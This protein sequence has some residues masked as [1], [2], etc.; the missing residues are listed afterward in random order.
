[1]HRS[2]II[3]G[4]LILII[5]A[6]TPIEPSQPEEETMVIGNDLT[7]PI[8]E[9]TPDI[10]T[11]ESLIAFYSNQDGN[12][13]IYTIQADG[14]GLQRLTNNDAFDDSPALSPDGKQIVFL[15]ARNDPY[16]IFPDFKY[17]IYLMDS[18]GENLRRLT[19]TEVGEDHPSWSPD[20]RKIL[21]DA[22][23]NGDGYY[24]I[25]TLDVEDLKLTQLTDNKAND[26]FAEW[27]PD[28]LW[29]AFSS[30]RNGNWDIFIMDADGNFQ[31][32]LTDSDNWELFPAWSPSVEQIAYQS[33]V[34]RS[35]NTDVFVM[36]AD[37][38]EAHQLTNSPGF[39]ESPTWSPDGSKIAFQ[40][41]RNGNFEIYVM[42]L[43]GS[44]QQPLL[45]LPSDELWPSWSL[46]ISP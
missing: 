2:M 1:M 16:P 45:T 36:N 42:N 17:E 5:T 18:N 15:S 10:P 46:I 26:Q 4:L 29:I 40:T 8:E 30:D 14:S 28:S 12:L 13:E 41:W 23:Y 39:D 44:D 24:E 37:G 34:P 7:P 32:A 19:Q 20:G 25:Y 31:Q 43:D 38:S 33:L 6:C 27:S 3:F 21:F 35:G 9:S 22:D 11:Q